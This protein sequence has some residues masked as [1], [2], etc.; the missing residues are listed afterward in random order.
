MAVLSAGPRAAFSRVFPPELR[1][2]AFP[3]DNHSMIVPFG[4]PRRHPPDHAILAPDEAGSP[5]VIASR[6]VSEV[7][8]LQGEVLR[9]DAAIAELLLNLVRETAAAR[10]DETRLLQVICDFAFQAFTTATHHVLAVRDGADG[11]FH[12]LIARSRTGE[13]PRVALS[14]TIVSRVVKD[15]I[16][17]L[18]THSQK[19]MADADSIALSGLQTAICA[20][21]MHGDE[22]FG[23]IQLDI[24][25]PGKGVFTKKHLDLLS[26]FASQV[27]LTL[28]H[29]YLYNQQRRALQSTISALVHSLNLKDPETAHHSERVQAVSLEIGRQLGLGDL[30]MEALGVAAL[31]HDLGKQGIRDELLFKPE[32]LSEDERKEMAR[33]AEHTQSILDRIEYPE[34]L[35]D[36]PKI[37]AYHH[38]KMDGTGPF[39]IAAEDI[40]RT[41]RIISVADVFDALMSPRAY[42]QPLGVDEVVAILEKGKDTNWDRAVVNALRQSIPTLEASIYSTRAKPAPPGDAQ[43]PPPVDRAA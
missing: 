5:T 6:P 26:V 3:T 14:R 11:E 1:F 42:K 7:K 13:E 2:H 17:L 29:L 18:V 35:R 19:G 28:D 24:R 41:S 20:P 33:H 22:A 43:A 39:G 4:P 23:I 25:R 8:E 10:N 12:P 15:G 32:G 36:V 31:L 27:S 38:E 30:D 34:H 40:P 16:A 37:A 21:L 9:S